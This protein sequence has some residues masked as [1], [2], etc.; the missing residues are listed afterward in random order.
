MQSN[1]C[2]RCSV[3]DLKSKVV[4]QNLTKYNMPLIIVANCPKQSGT[5]LLPTLV[6]HTDPALS[7]IVAI[8][9]FLFHYCNYGD[10][11]RLNTGR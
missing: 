2:I 7:Q 1:N 8:G 4:V 5:V 11:L 6:L 3:V 10:V 9:L